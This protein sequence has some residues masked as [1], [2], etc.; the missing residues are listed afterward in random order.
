MFCTNCGKDNPDTNKF[1]LQ[2]GQPLAAVAGPTPAG[3]APSPPAPPRSSNR[4]PLILGGALLL[5]AL[6]AAAWFLLPRLL[7]GG[8]EEILVAIPQPDR[9][10]DRLLFDL[11][12]LRL[13]DEMSE[14]VTI[15][16]EVDI[17]GT[18]IGT[19]GTG[20]DEYL[21][22]I[23]GLFGGF[24][25]G[26]DRLVTF[27]AGSESLD[28]LFV[29]DY[30]LGEEAPT[31]I[32]SGEEMGFLGAFNPDTRD[33]FIQSRIDSGYRCYLAAPG[34]EAERLARGDECFPTGDGRG[35]ITQ[36]FSNGELTV[37]LTDMASG[38]ETTLLDDVEA[39]GARVSADGSH[40]VYVLVE[41]SE[42][43]AVLADAAGETLFTGDEYEQIREY[44]FAGLG[45]TPYF[46]ALEDDMWALYSSSGDGSLIDGPA[47]AVL[48]APDGETIAVITADEDGA[49][50]VSVVNLDDGAVTEVISGDFL[51]M[52]RTS[53]PERLLI[54]EEI[55]G[56]LVLTAAEPSGANPV[57]LFDDN[58][59]TL[60]D[61]IPVPGDNRLYLTLL[62]VDGWSLYVAP[63]DGSPGFF[64]LE[65]WSAIT[66]LNGTDDT[67]VFIGQEDSGDDNVLFALPLEADADPIELDDSADSYY[68]SF[69]TPDDRSIIYTAI[70]EN[71]EDFFIRQVRLDGEEPPEDLY[72]DALLIDA[73]WAESVMIDLWF[74]TST[75][76]WTGA[77]Q[78][79]QPADGG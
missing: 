49:G 58:D 35:I 17:A 2:C 71:E 11:A 44:G 55:D 75:L 60:V 64:A 42:Y 25:P 34:E 6:A 28:Q 1:C 77:G 40:V 78:P 36:D 69:I 56:D 70:E 66:L 23:G 3:E 30:I 21:P 39:S 9:E 65:E 50:E 51:Q 53:D 54:K 12:V 43:T 18:Y 13:G 32:I 37:T 19:M 29:L 79:A 73:R 27:F 46:I 68:F 4:L 47:L 8:G 57:T 72:D 20:S 48:L 10:L 45:D 15:A 76:S 41:D 62:S 24:L 61:I 67:L 33:L 52:S 22:V 38:D 59:Y 14:A 26:T 16:E 5:V 31:E 7:G 63:L 74:G